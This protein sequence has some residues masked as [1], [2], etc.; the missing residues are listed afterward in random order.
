MIG[1][2]GAG[3]MGS[4]IIKGLLTSGTQPQDIFVY[5]VYEP[6]RQEMAEKG[7]NVCDSCRDLVKKCRYIFL[8]IKPI[9]YPSVLNEISILLKG[10]VLISM[11]PGYSIKDIKHIIGETNKVVR[12][13]PNTPAIAGAGFTAIAY[14]GLLT[15]EETKEVENIINIFSIGTVTDEYYMNAFSAVTGSGPA[16]VFMMIEAM[17]D[18]AVLLGISRK[19]A[20]VAVEQMVMG[21]A[22]LALE[23]QM[24]PGELKDMVCSP[25]GITIEGVRTL[26]ELNFR[27]SLIE[28][29]I[30]TYKKN[31]DLNVIR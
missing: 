20:Y 31:L 26:E 11:A 18:A 29:V 14:D 27:S 24:H 2:I 12:I 10:K 8:S 22:K 25:G 9:V 19:D 17:A 16:F 4:A 15:E 13:M 7:V 28:C 6:K 1:F 21:S 30:N 3:N 5:E 23:T